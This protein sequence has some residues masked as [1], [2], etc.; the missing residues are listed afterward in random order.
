MKSNFNTCVFVDELKNKSED[1]DYIHVDNIEEMT[2]KMKQCKRVSIIERM[3]KTFRDKE[4]V[5]H[6]CVTTEKGFWTILER[7]LVNNTIPVYVLI[8]SDIPKPFVKRCK[9][10]KKECE[11]D[12]NI[13]ISLKDI[14][15]KRMIDR[16]RESKM[17]ES[18][19]HAFIH[20]EY[21]NFKS[22]YC[23]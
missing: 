18:Y 16:Y 13:D 2:H 8:T 1:I 6:P 19:V 20:Q 9:I 3:T 10:I 5:I 23:K 22:L 14:T 21:I 11:V 4:L 12:D 17:V 7:M 15:K